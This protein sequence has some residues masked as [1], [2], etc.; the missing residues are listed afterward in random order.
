MATPSSR[1]C[2]LRTP[3][4]DAPPGEN[5]PYTPFYRAWWLS[6]HRAGEPVVPAEY[7]ALLTEIQR[8]P[9]PG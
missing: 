2:R 5:N 3:G 8:L 9:L 6:S 7:S 4:R 1:S